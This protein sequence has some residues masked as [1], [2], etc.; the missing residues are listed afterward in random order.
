MNALKEGDRVVSRFGGHHVVIAIAAVDGAE[1]WYDV[2]RDDGT[3]REF[4]LSE[5]RPW[6]E[7]F[8]GEWKGR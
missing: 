3:K 4:H 2:L 6:V 7:D 8:H 5:L 1:E